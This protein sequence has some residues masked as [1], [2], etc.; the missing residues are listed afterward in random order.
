M[1]DFTSVS[2]PTSEQGA[3][4][5][6]GANTAPIPARATERD[7]GN[8]AAGQGET[9]AAHAAVVAEHH[10]TAMEALALV[11]AHLHSGG[12]FADVG[13]GTGE[14]AAAMAERHFKVSAT[15]GSP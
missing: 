15:D 10:E 3:A 5:D 13:C 1:P 4:P 9:E 14:V 7:A 6:P 12:R 8:G 11:G 2:A